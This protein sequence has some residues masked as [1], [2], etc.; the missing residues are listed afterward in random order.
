RTPLDAIKS[1]ALGAKAVGMS[2]PFLNQVEHAGI[3]STIE[4]VESFIDHMKSIMTMLDA[5]DINDL[6]QSKIVFDSKLMSWIEQR[7]L[8]VER[9]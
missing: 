5:K 8:K 2:R 1:L 3:T 7:H 9:G 4:Y 6:K